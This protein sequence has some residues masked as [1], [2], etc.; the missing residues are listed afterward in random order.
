MSS[1]GSPGFVSGPYLEFYSQEADSEP[2]KRRSRSD[3]YPGVAPD[4][5][6]T[7]GTR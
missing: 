3:S 7:I 6:L 2:R 5:P 4:G 1:T